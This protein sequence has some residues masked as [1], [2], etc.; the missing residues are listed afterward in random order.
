MSQQRFQDTAAA[1]GDVAD[2]AEAGDGGI[3]S[4]IK[5]VCAASCG[6]G[7]YGVRRTRAV[8]FATVALTMLAISPNQTTTYV[9][10][11]GVVQAY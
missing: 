8:V 2:A 3:P 6:P 5:G 7:W 11:L 1:Q 10:R 9:S 4:E